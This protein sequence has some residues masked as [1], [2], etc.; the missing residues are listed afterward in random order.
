[1]SFL[2]RV[3]A[4]NLDLMWSTRLRCRALV[5][6]RGELRTMSAS[7]RP[8][9]T[10]REKDVAAALQRKGIERTRVPESVPIETVPAQVVG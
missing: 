1:M 4:F 10:T 2:G 9:S 6:T 7:S 8:R 5:K 3:D